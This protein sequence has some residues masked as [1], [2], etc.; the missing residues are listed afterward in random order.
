MERIADLMADEHNF[1]VDPINGKVVVK[2]QRT[3]AEIVLQKVREDERI[4]Q[5][6]ASE[7]S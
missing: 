4:Q 5:Q 1:E 6:S 3:K 7:Q 2:D